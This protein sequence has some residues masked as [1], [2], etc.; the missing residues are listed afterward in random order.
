M[1]E[2]MTQYVY[3]FN[4]KI[5]VGGASRAYEIYLSHKELGKRL[6]FINLID[7]VVLFNSKRMYKERDK[8]WSINSETNL[9]FSRTRKGGMR[10]IKRTENLLSAIRN[11]KKKEEE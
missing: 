7:A 1:T 2:D 5:K 4:K 6:T 10:L 8:L 11:I 9:Q 3:E